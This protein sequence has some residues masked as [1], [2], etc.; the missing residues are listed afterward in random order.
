MKTG[1]LK[2]TAEPHGTLKGGAVV[3]ANW[4][5]F[6]INSKTGALIKPY[7]PIL[8]TSTHHIS[9]N[10]EKGYL[11]KDNYLLVTRIPNILCCGFKSALDKDPS[12][13]E[14]GL[15][16]LTIFGANNGVGTRGV[17]LLTNGIGETAL[18][19][20]LDELV[21][22]KNPKAFQALFYLSS[23]RSKEDDPGFDRPRAIE[24]V[25][26]SIEPLD[27]ITVDQY[28]AA[29]DAGMRRL[30]EEELLGT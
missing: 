27:W 30:M 16:Y 9:D 10:G 13:E 11:I 14:G 22:H 15:P 4:P 17:E 19:D 2:I 3:G 29:W 7:V 21:G 18:D 5:I 23:L 12:G 25:Q 20:F 6:R 24:Y 28:T 1:S 26:G 8:D